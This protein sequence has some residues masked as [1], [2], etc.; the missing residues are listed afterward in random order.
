M[1][2]YM[3]RIRISFFLFGA[4]CLLCAQFFLQPPKQDNYVIDYP[5]QLLHQSNESSSSRRLNHGDHFSACI[6]IMD[7]NHYLPEWL[8]Y[9]YTFLPLRRLIVAVDPNSQTSPKP[10]LDQFQD[11][12]NITL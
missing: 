11:L 10:I 5:H 2:D 6:L 1:I 12:I 3:P 4:A 7:D 9:H 8:A